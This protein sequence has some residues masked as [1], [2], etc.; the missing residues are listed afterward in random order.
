MP[1]F[2]K[3]LKSLKTA[4]DITVQSQ[5]SAP[6]TEFPMTTLEDR[7]PPA[8]PELHYRVKSVL[9]AR[10]DI[11]STELGQEYHGMWCKTKKLV[12]GFF[13][14][15]DKKK[16]PNGFTPIDDITECEHK[17]HHG[18]CK[19][20]IVYAYETSKATS[21]FTHGSSSTTSETPQ[22]QNQT[23][24]IST[25]TMIRY[26]DEEIILRPILETPLLQTSDGIGIET[27]VHNIILMGMP[28]PISD[29]D[30]AVSPMGMGM[31]TLLRTLEAAIE[32][33]N[34]SPFPP[35]IGVSSP[36]SSPFEAS[37]TNTVK[38]I[39]YHATLKD[40][41]RDH[42][43]Q[44][45]GAVVDGSPLSGDFTI[46][47]WS[48]NEL[49]LHDDAAS[50]Y[51]H[52][53][54]F[55]PFENDTPILICTRRVRT[56]NNAARPQVFEDPESPS[57]RRGPDVFFSSPNANFPSS[58]RRP[59]QLASSALYNT[60]VG[61]GDLEL[62]EYHADEQA[63]AGVDD[64]SILNFPIQYATPEQNM[65]ESNS[66]WRNSSPTLVD[67]ITHV[68]S[69]SNY[70][71]RLL[72]QSAELEPSSTES[73]RAA[74]SSGTDEDEGYSSSSSTCVPYIP[75]SNINIH[76]TRRRVSSLVRSQGTTN[77]MANHARL[78]SLEFVPF[79]SFNANAQTSLD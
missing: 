54:D 19:S 58:R 15:K 23:P 40:T 46:R 75:S 79:T 70:H 68:R 13:K 10:P 27:L 59:E 50:D 35:Q 51:G 11:V 8:S 44:A 53:S 12:K 25:E 37:D 42:F 18:Q 69:I 49:F 78:P 45:D 66:D 20:Y 65:A 9:T 2:L 72:M 63:E 77:L 6:R 34:I 74:N 31:P 43:I 55:G 1:S 16:S 26:V 41:L 38:P 33:N 39:T 64:N 4:S 7:L 21:V 52:S 24:S 17:F 56:P 29:V 30:S 5:I 60:F 71:E 36:S 73:Q 32:G 61:T 57:Y 3:K 28:T 76:R 67:L 22:N 14:S 47:N 62:A 48:S